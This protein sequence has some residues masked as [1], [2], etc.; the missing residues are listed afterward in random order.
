MKSAAKAIQRWATFSLYSMQMALR[1]RFIP[2]H[3]DKLVIKSLAQLP[4][5]V[6]GS[7]KAHH[8]RDAS[9]H[10]HTLKLL[11]DLLTLASLS[12]PGIKSESLA[13]THFL[14]VTVEFKLDFK[15][16]WHQIWAT[17]S[18]NLDAASNGATSPRWCIAA[19]C[20]AQ[21]ISGTILDHGCRGVASLVQL[22]LVEIWTK[23]VPDNQ[24]GLDEQLWYLVTTTSTVVWD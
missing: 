24:H 10:L 14:T 22:P 9:I 13:G 3:C 23:G 15:L 18:S 20:N 19:S 1:W 6:Q 16:T 21:T 12:H 7:L 4:C 8:V 11:V 2:G 17:G 5:A